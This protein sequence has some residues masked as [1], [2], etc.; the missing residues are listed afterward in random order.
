MN[1]ANRV[2]MF[3]LLVLLPLTGSGIVQY[4]VDGNLGASGWPGNVVRNWEQYGLLT[5]KGKLVTNP[6]GFEALTKPEVYKGH[7]A[8][9]LYPV[10]FIK[11]LFAWTGAGTLAFNVA[12]SLTLLLSIWFLLGK[13]RIAWLAGA[14]TILCPGYLLYQATLDPNAIA[15]LLGL[16]FAAIVLTLLAKPSLSPLALAALLLTIAAYT[17]LNWTTVFGH[18]IL[19]ACLVAAQEIPRRRRVLYVALAG[20]SLIMVAGTSVLAKRAGATGS[21]MEFLK[22]Y[23]WGAEGY[24]TYLTIDRAMV[25]LLFVGIVGL[26]P[27]L[28]V[29]GHVL[30][31][32]AKSN[33]ERL[34][35]AFSPLGAA[36]LGVGIM[37]NYFGHHPWMA[38]PAFLVGL[39]LSMWL[40]VEGQRATLTEQETP[41][42]RK[43]LAP[44]A[45]LAACFVYGAVVAV[46]PSLQNSDSHALTILLRTHT[47]RSDT[48]MV[49]DADPKL[50]SI[51]AGVA[52]YG[53]RRVVVLNDL[54]AGEHIGG[55]AFLLSTSGEMKLPLVAKTSQPALAS[56][57]PV[58]ELL[59]FYSTRV[60]R[61]F[62]EN[63][64]LR[65]GAC[66]LYELNNDKHAANN[67]VIPRHVHWSRMSHSETPVLWLCRGPSRSSSRKARAHSADGN[68]P[69]RAEL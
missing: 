27:L 44:A 10:F 15:V 6:G 61:R 65:P 62:P 19:L 21:F 47:V 9:S 36:V 41:V 33:P 56:W 66:Y 69:A 60:S 7:R 26:L 35:V 57:P 18:G 38:V 22:G 32:R 31:Q 17:M 1:F 37:R 51:A 4:L 25:R 30:A 54:S 49:A 53:D 5:L 39:V 64:G 43:L 16:P 59:A 63:R 13:S 58:R 11:R 45:F 23:S 48:I 3:L 12:L 46:M 50:S 14:A 2:P 67:R 28:L 8:A 42:G 29:C 68:A 52:E 24:G 40:M 20:V 34:W 55:R